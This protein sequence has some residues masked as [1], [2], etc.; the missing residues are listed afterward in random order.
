MKIEVDDSDFEENV[1]KQSEKIPVIVDFW[2]EWCMP[3]LMLGPVLEKIAVEHGGRFILAKI[4]VDKS[5]ETSQ[6][7]G[8]M[9]IPAVKIFKNGKVSDEFIGVLPEPHVRQWVVKN[10]DGEGERY[11]FRG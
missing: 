7:Y 8:I 5:P 9:S 3:C 6:R 1:I 2:A 4:N 10:M 11:F